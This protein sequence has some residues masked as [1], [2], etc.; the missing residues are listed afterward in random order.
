MKPLTSGEIEI[1]Q[2]L[3]DR[4]PLTPPELQSLFPRKIKNAAL[5]AGL[6]VL[7]E[8]GHVSRTK[9]GRAYLYKAVTQQRR[10]FKKMVTNLKHIFCD[11]SPKALIAQLINMENLSDEEIDE[12]RHIVANK[13]KQK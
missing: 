3:W 12:L 8:K 6:L 2:L 1:M 9:Q 11:G 10:T 13:K 4:G 5:R 7:L